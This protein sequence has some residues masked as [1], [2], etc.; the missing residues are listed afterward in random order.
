MSEKEF[1]SLLYTI[2]ANT[3]NLIME[4]TGWSEDMATERFV[5]SKV[6]SKLEREKTKGW[7]YSATMLAQLFSD[8]RAG[9]L[10][11]PEGV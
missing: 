5:M 8:E 10:V 6:Y 1:E 9:M 3:V 7:H 4:Q 2:T 11:W